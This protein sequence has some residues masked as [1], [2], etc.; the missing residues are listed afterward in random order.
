[1]KWLDVPCIPLFLNQIKTPIDR[2]RAIIRLRLLI[3]DTQTITLDW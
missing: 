1:M 3:T 2:I